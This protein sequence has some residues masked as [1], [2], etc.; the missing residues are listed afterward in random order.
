MKPIQLTERFINQL[1]SQY[2]YIRS[3]NPAAADR[4]RTRV[5]AGVKRLGEFPE[6]GSAWKRAG[7]RELVL[8]G[9]PF[10]II[11]QVKDDMVGVLSLL[12]T[13]REAP[14]VH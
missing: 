9:L 2:E 6:S 13:S 3:Q 8:P 11:Y 1:R 12:H 14:D 7:T 5:L 4:V 10:I